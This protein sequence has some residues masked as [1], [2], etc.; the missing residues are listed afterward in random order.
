LDR[1]LKRYQVRSPSIEYNL[2][3]K[4]ADP[5]GTHSLGNALTWSLKLEG[6][7]QDQ[8]ASGQSPP[9]AYSGVSVLGGSASVFVPQGT[10]AALTVDAPFLTTE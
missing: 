5:W 4:Q 1:H 10:F 9:V 7:G 2:P 8:S 6:P 3:H